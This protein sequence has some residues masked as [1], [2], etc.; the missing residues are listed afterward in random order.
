[1]RYGNVE[2]NGLASVLFEA[3]PHRVKARILKA[4]EALRELPVERWPEQGVKRLSTD[5]PLFLLAWGP[6]LRIFL[7][8][9]EAGTIELVDMVRQETL[10]W[11][12]GTKQ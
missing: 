3:Q 11:M 6:S 7:R 5:E 1:M 10:D 2:V 9:G 12:T 4:V 8:P